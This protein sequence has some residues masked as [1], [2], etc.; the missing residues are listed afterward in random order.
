V[1]VGLSL[2]GALALLGAGAPNAAATRA[3]VKS[4]EERLV[5]RPDDLDARARALQLYVLDRSPEGRAAFARHALWAIE[6]A[7]ASEA[8][9][10]PY[11]GLGGVL[12]PVAQEEAR[13]LW[14]R[15]IERHA[16]DAAVLGN[17]STFFL[18]SDEQ[19]AEE[20]LVM[21]ALQEPASI[22]WP[23]RL[24][25][26][27]SGKGA[28]GAPDPNAAPAALEIYEA[29]LGLTTDDAE[30]SL[31]LADVADVARRAGNPAKARAYAQELLAHAGRAE[32]WDHG[33]AV[34]DANR[35]L[36]HLALDRGDVPAARVHLLAAGAAPGSPQLGSFGPELTLANALLA[37]GERAAVVEYLKLCQRFWTHRASDVQSWIAAIEAGQTIHLDR[38]RG[39]VAQP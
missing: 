3:D 31:L 10:L 32:H 25:R 4:L 34:H 13:R 14:L 39:A 29:A 5:G 2:A 24:G 37:A 30:R 9:G 22:E 15:A 26:L 11:A 8:A 33:N 1:I 7:P 35:V 19:R 38:F 6:N 17:A 12:Q 28:Y 20:L 21:A 36:G 16:E 27:Y 23:V 18:F